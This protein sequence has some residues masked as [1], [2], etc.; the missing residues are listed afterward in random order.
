MFYKSM[1]KILTDNIQEQMNPKTNI[2]V[3]QFWRRIDNL[4]K[5]QTDIK[6][7]LKDMQNDNLISNFLS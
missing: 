1:S 7:L 5:L 3:Q 6:V 2:K 4:N